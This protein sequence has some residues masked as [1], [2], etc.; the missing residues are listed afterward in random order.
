M[1]VQ[2]IEGQFM[3]VQWIE[4]QFMVQWIEGK[5]MLAMIAGRN[6]TQAALKC[7]WERNSC[8]VAG[9]W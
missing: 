7:S 3:L 1:L 2:W 9:L 4:G 8:L 5:F 6:L